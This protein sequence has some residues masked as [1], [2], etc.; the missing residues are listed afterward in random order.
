MNLLHRQI[1]APLRLRTNSPSTFEIPWILIHCA[2]VSEWGLKM[3]KRE[4]HCRPRESCVCVCVRVCTHKKSL[5]HIPGCFEFSI[6]GGVTLSRSTLTGIWWSVLLFA[7]NKHTQQN[8]LRWTFVA[9]TRNK[10]RLSLWIFT[11]VQLQNQN[12]LGACVG[13]C[14]IN[15]VRCKTK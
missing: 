11:Y 13:K 4:C 7:R 2:K 9:Y 15:I 1:A 3:W 5:H 8:N 14:T 6:G 12:K 10:M